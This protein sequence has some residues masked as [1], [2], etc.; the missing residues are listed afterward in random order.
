MAED[1][2]V[3][4]NKVIAITPADYPDFLEKLD[5][6]HIL[7]T[8]DA[9]TLLGIFVIERKW[10]EG[11][12]GH[13]EKQ[14]TSFWKNETGE[15]IPGWGGKFR[16]CEEG[17]D[18]N[19][20]CIAEF[21]SETWNVIKSK[22]FRIAIEPTSENPNVRVTTG[23]WKADY[24]G[25][26]YNC[27]NDVEVDEDGTMFIE[28]NIPMYD[29][30]LSKI[31]E[32][33]LL[34]TGDGYTLLEIYQEEEVWVE[35]DE[36]A[37]E[38]VVIWENETGEA[39]SGWGGKFRFCE[40]G[41]DSQNECIAEISS[42][43]WSIMKDETFYAVIEPAENPN[44]RITTGWWKADYGGTEHNCIDMADDDLVSGLK[45]IA[46][47][48]SQ[49]ADFYEKIDEQHILFTGDAYTLKKLYYIK[50]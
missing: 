14:R 40:E 43:V 5:E 19:N 17:H 39:I 22:P 50:K 2:I 4:D 24:G 38:Q 11:E 30:F 9:Y 26:E 16:F 31:D 42:D 12:G 36:S 3:A 29:D 1:D 18:F 6:Q 32:Q 23:W 28:L 49:F 15:A 7:F 44:V 25:T 8:G 13:F 45:V 34:F 48:P 27:F 21:D 41:H 35:G 47:T 46:V 33:H 20:E 37:P 10:V